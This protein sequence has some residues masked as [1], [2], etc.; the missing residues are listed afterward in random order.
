MRLHIFQKVPQIPLH[1][2][3][4]EVM[5]VIGA[6]WENIKCI[7]NVPK[8]VKILKINKNL[9][10]LQKCKNHYCKNK[11]VVVNVDYRTHNLKIQEKLLTY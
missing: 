2:V 1:R 9:L 7:I 5:M 8:T 6:T 4:C 3:F 11:T 10:L